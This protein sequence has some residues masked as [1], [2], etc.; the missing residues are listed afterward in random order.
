MPHPK[1]A[2]SY[3]SF[4]FVR[5]A[6]QHCGQLLPQRSAAAQGRNHAVGPQEKFPRRLPGP[7]RHKHQAVEIRHRQSLGPKIRLRPGTLQ[8]REP[9]PL[10]AV[11][12][13]EQPDDPVAEPALAVVKQHGIREGK[14]LGCSHVRSAP[15]LVRGFHRLS[16]VAHEARGIPAAI[17]GVRVGKRSHFRIPDRA[18]VE[19]ELNAPRLLSRGVVPLPSDAVPQPGDVVEVRYTGGPPLTIGQGGDW[20]VPWTEWLKGSALTPGPIPVPP[21]SQSV[22]PAPGP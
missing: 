7:I 20:T 18:G 2:A 9:Q 19:L 3:H 10:A 17:T 22:T 12:P 21:P 15:R 1:L 8:P 11:E 5:H 14:L 6:R 13:Q 16:Q 4:L